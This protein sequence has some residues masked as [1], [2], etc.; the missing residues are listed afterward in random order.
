[1]SSRSRTATSPLRDLAFNIQKSSLTVADECLRFRYEE[2]PDL[3][4]R[5]ASRGEMDY[6]EVL[7]TVH[8]LLDGRITVPE[9]RAAL[10]PYALSSL[11]RL[12][13]GLR[14]PVQDFSEPADISSRGPDDPRVDPAAPGRAPAE[15]QANLAV[16]NFDHVASAPRRRPRAGHAMDPHRGARSSGE[17]PARS[18]RGRLARGVQPALRRPGAPAGLRS[19]TAR[20]RR[21]TA[22]AV[23]VPDDLV[24]DDPDSP[25][26]HHHHVDV[27]ARPQ[28]PHG[29]RVARGADLAQ[30]RDPCR[31]RLL[32]AGVRRPARVGHRH[33]PAHPAD[34]DAGER[35]DV[36][37]PQPRDRPEPR[38]LRHL[39]G[40]RRLG[41]S[42]ADRAS[43]DAAARI[44][45][46]WWPRTRRALRVSRRPDQPEGRL[47]LLPASP[48]RR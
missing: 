31:R 45:P 38:G 47:Q 35:R 41:P 15:G 24:V 3:I 48:R 43:G 40:L 17:R 25:A 30:P 18:H 36:Q 20:E 6:A 21:S 39:P 32:A 42:R 33:R 19:P 46:G 7:A 9:A 44:P 11:A 8:D 29:G 14:T 23:D 1:M 5:M 26:R 34:E 16:G 10:D 37:D 4:A 27:Q 12:M 2:S 13:V 22:L 28:L